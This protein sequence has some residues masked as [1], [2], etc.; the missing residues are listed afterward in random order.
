MGSKGGLGEGWTASFLVGLAGL[1]TGFTRT[2]WEVAAN[3]DP[4]FRQNLLSAPLTDPQTLQIFIYKPVSQ[5]MISR[6]SSFF[7][8]LAYLILRG[9]KK[10]LLFSHEVDQDVT[11]F[12]NV[13]VIY[14]RQRCL[15]EN[16][17][18]FALQGVGYGADQVFALI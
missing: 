7:L 13:R 1:A 9:D 10:S 14:A 2:G 12:V 4:H 16:K 15:Q 3:G 17:S 18:F 11:E 6:V 8:C 5:L